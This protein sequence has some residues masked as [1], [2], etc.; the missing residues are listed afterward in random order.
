M[1]HLY[2]N[3]CEIFTDG[4]LLKRNKNS[5]SDAITMTSF[6]RD[7]HGSPPESLIVKVAEVIGSFRTLRKMV[8]FWSRVVAEVSGLYKNV[9]IRT[10]YKCFMLKMKSYSSLCLLFNLY[11]FIFLK[12]YVYLYMGEFISTHNWTFLWV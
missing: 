7:I 6:P 11:A 9:F 4:Q 2:F 3:I 1:F 12:G 10:L 8:L 5:G